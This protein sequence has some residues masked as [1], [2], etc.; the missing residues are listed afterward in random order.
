MV[1][2]ADISK[3]EALQSGYALALDSKNMDG[4]LDCFADDGTY[5]CQTLESFSDGL[6][7][8]FMWDDRL[9]RLKDRV[10]AVTEVWAGTAEEYQPRHFGQRLSA[11]PGADG[12]VE[13]V[14]NFVVFYTTNRGDSQVLATGQYLDTIR[15]SDDAAKFVSRKAIL[16]Q[17][18]VPRY[19]VYPI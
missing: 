13:T 18:V 16:D 17:T 5:L 10:K 12:L 4:W 6:P 19:L 15:V 9:G 11:K 7:V 8:G 1:N 3:I 14:S 2:P